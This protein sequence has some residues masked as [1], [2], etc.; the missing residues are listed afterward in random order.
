MG[1]ETG[2]PGSQH[3]AQHHQEYDFA[4]VGEPTR[5][6]V[7]HTHK[8]C[9]WLQL[10][11]YG[12]A[13]HG[14]TPERGI[15][16]IAEMV[17]I[18]SALTNDFTT[19]L[20]DP[21]WA[22]PV[23]GSPTLNIG[24]IRGGTRTNIVPEKCTIDLDLRETPALHAYGSERFLRE[25]L[26]SQAWEKTTTLTSTRPCPPLDIAADNA[27]VQIF[28]SLGCPLTGA[29]WLCDA[30]W[31]SAL[32]GIPSVAIGPGDIAQAHTADEFIDLHELSLGTTLYRDFI[33]ALR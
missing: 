14:S 19:A 4:V 7:V 11:T 15:N 16:A 30:T 2:Q 33:L 12:R 23:L 31:L 20:R 3:F 5:R 10:Q 24:R 22:H 18:F 21:R 13:C 6:E 1:E 25:W 32:G 29:P 8:G 26:A 9:T 28:A 27:H 17:P